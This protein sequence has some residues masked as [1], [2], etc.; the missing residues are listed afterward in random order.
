M[1]LIDSIEESI[2]LT[3]Y[4]RLFLR[5]SKLMFDVYKSQT[6]IYINE[7]F[8]LRAV[9]ENLHVLRSSLSSNFTTIDLTEKY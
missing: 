1:T 6:P 7:M 9:D 5:K 2:V 8:N 3:I 4:E